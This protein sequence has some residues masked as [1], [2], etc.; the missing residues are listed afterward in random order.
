MVAGALYLTQA[1]CVLI[2]G[3][4]LYAVR[5]VELA[6]FLRVMIRREFSFSSLTKVDRIFLLLYSY[7]AMV[8]VLRAT[9]GLANVIGTSVDAFLCYFTFRGLIGD[10][11][12]FQ[13]FLRAFLILLVPYTALVIVESLTL[14]NPF[15]VIGAS[16]IPWLREG[17]ARCTGSFRY[18]S[19]LGTFGVSFMPLYFGLTFVRASR[20]L[21]WIGVG[22]CVVIV[23]ASNSGGPL[24]GLAAVVLGWLL[25]KVRAKMR[26]VRW[27][28]VSLIVALALL[29]KAPVWY[30]LARAS[31]IV[32]G[33]GWHRAYLIDV[34][35]QHLDKWWLAGMP[36]K[37]TADW[38]PYT[39]AVTGGA[40]ITNAF[41]AFGLTAGLTSLVLYIMLMVRGF[42]SL[43]TALAA[44]RYNSKD[45]SE[46]EFILWGLGVMFAAHVVN[47]LGVPYFDQFYLIWFMQLAAI[48]GISAS[49]AEAA[50]IRTNGSGNHPDEGCMVQPV[51][52]GD[53]EK[54][55]ND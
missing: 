30:L 18:A 47:Q 12:D 19:L 9:E 43:G 32:G 22:L 54:M 8:Y 55:F 25:W 46:A 17:R 14:Q 38:F 42:N 28:M 24:S 15:A 37:E 23:W 48:S 16:T 5:F 33:D 11:L 26:M 7:T 10:L 4:N 13:W 27:V 45:A 29:M 21:A 52:G 6:G 31:N 35:L 41:I 44:V 34:A 20:I 1:Q 39:I 50:A 2:A 51:M 49:C 53:V 40:D 3:F 36:I